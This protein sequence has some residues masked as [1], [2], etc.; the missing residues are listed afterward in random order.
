M[1]SED[2]EMLA[3]L[4]ALM[5]LHPAIL[6]AIPMEGGIQIIVDEDADEE[7]I[8]DLTEMMTAA[9]SYQQVTQLN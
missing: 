9:G 6:Q 1:S 2:E 4:A 7:Y 5:E 3:V 8:E